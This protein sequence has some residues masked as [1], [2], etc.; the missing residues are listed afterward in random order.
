MHEGR[1]QVDWSRCSSC[2]REIPQHPG[3]PL[4]YVTCPTILFPRL[5]RHP[6]DLHLSDL[7]YYQTPISW[8]SVI[9][10]PQS[11]WVLVI[12]LYTHTLPQPP[13]DR[14]VAPLPAAPGGAAAGARLR[15]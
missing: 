5:V 12:T 10:Y 13:Q 11:T 2:I 7:Y 9:F 14:R 3:L 6:I 15:G 4:Q 1:N 8:D